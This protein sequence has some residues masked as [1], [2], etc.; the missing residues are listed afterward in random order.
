M[1]L[2]AIPTASGTSHEPVC[3]VSYV[4]P[5]AALLI[6]GAPGLAVGDYVICCTFGTRSPRTFP[7]LDLISLTGS[8]TLRQRI[9]I[10]LTVV[11]SSKV[12]WGTLTDEGL[13]EQPE[14]MVADEAESS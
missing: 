13:Q 8:T 3:R 5:E 7:P 4:S 14:G 9:P 12:L 1:G 11:S 10:G 2:E 6:E